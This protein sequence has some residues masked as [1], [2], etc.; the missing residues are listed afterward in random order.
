ML[1]QSG[2]QHADIL[3]VGHHG[4]KNGTGEELL[5]QLRPKIAIVSAGKKNRYGHPHRETV[6]RLND[7]GCSIYETSRSGMLWF[8]MERKRWYLNPKLD[9]MKQ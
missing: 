1:V 2:I 6:R 4:S 5:R 8:S 7:S 9:I 3:K